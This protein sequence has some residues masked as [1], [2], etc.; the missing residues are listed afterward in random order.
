[1]SG[2]FE[3]PAQSLNSSVEVYIP[4]N[5]ESCSLPSLPDSRASHTMNGLIICG[6][7]DTLTSCICFSSGQWITSHSLHEK[8]R[9]HLSWET[10]SS[11]LLMEIGRG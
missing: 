5:G 3:V 1:M 6:G 2:G 11:I 8:R 4:A 10:N 9:D 7:W